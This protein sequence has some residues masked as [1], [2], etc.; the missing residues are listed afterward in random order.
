VIENHAASAGGALIDRGN[1][2][3]QLLLPEFR[4]PVALARPMLFSQS[5]MMAYQ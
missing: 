4:G 3:G 5:T 1:E 2:V